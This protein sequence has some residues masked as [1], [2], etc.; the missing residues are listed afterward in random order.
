MHIYCYKLSKKNQ[1]TDF[2][3]KRSWQVLRSME[4]YFSVYIL[5]EIVIHKLIT[6][7]IETSTWGRG[8]RR[9]EGEEQL[10]VGEKGK[11]SESQC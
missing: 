7:T 10:K 5:N 1:I 11:E 3:N 9:K 8:E 4:P 6:K 2:T